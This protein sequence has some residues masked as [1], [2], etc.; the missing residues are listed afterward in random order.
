MA[1]NN[2]STGRAA[3]EI[4]AF[5]AVRLG[6]KVAMFAV[7][8]CALASMT[9]TVCQTQTA[10]CPF[11]YATRNPETTTGLLLVVVIL[12]VEVA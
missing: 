4:L 8:E 5:W 11:A 2:I 3:T 12:G 6:R 7:A 9:V 10:K 1:Q